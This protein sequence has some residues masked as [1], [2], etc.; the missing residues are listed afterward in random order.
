MDLQGA[1]LRNFYTITKSVGAGGGNNPLKK[2]NIPYYQRPYKWETKHVAN[3]IND[4]RYESNK[5]KEAENQP[6]ET[7][8]VYFAGSII[9]VNAKSSEKHD[10]IDGQQRF[11]TIFL[12]NFLLMLILRVT[13]RLAI[14]TNQ[15]F[16]I[17]ALFDDFQIS[18]DHLLHDAQQITE[19][20][21]PTPSDELLKIFNPENHELKEK[22]LEKFCKEVNLPNK[23]VK[24]YKG[25][26]KKNL[27]SF[28]S[29][30]LKLGYSRKSYNEK[31]VNALS[32]VIIK[33]DGD[34]NLKI[35]IADNNFGKNSVEL[36]FLNAV[37]QL[38]KSFESTDK[39]DAFINAE[40][41]I[42]SIKLFLNELSLCVIQTG[43]G[44]DAY[45]LFEVLNDRSMALDDLDLIKNH[46][47]KTFCLTGNENENEVNKQ[48]DDSEDIWS[49]VFG[50]RNE[51]KK[52]LISY[53]AT[54][55]ITGAT[56]IALKSKNNHRTAIKKYLEDGCFNNANPYNAEQLTKDFNIFHAVMTLTEEFNVV[57]KGTGS[58]AVEAEYDNKTITYQTVHLL[59]ALNQF[60]VLA[61]L[62]NFIL[63]YIDK[64]GNNNFNP[65]EA[66]ETIK[67]IM[68]NKEK[69]EIVHK[70]AKELWKCALFSG[71]YIEPRE[72]ARDVITLSH[73]LAKNK[74]IV[75]TCKEK[76]VNWAADWD[77][78]K[79]QKVK[80]KVLFARLIGSI[81]TDENGVES[82]TAFKQTPTN[83][84]YAKKIE[85]DHMEPSSP[86]PKM[87]PKFYFQQDDSLQRNRIIN[88]LGN[89][90]PLPSNLN[91][92]K[93]NRPMYTIFEELNKP[94]VGLKGHWLIETTLKSLGK[95]GNHTLAI[96]DEQEDKKI[97]TE[98]FFTERKEFI[99]KCFNE[100]INSSIHKNEQ[101]EWVY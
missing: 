29:D 70:Q 72:L 79:D 17:K 62:V 77:Y 98:K 13:L 46:F 4:W 20:S 74:Q 97:P 18:L 45:T 26:H 67:E 87:P 66:K 19:T 51:S 85:L 81:Q 47:Y 27:N 16:S 95:E 36:T 50:D 94:E 88:A 71:N 83:L 84:D 3:L 76:E 54:I 80:V 2:I 59:Q 100:A 39:K 25:V 96:E 21:T 24:D 78:D 90:M 61:G 22:F 64:Q 73:R 58:K 6:R 23:Q 99:I 55:Y 42:A 7:I 53:L 75:Q 89:M 69:H 92:I 101:G 32:C 31:L 68:N 43:N 56:D 30:K 15:T 12:T 9:T 34:Q 10:L 44:L 14:K 40:D 60:G 8:G 52:H 37:G 65:E 91:K 41:T 57:H 35:S 11:T 86:D 63:R 1:K 82:N 48:I 5:V 93:T 28:I 38:F 49:L 33:L